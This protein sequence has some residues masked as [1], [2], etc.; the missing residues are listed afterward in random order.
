MAYDTT[1]DEVNNPNTNFVQP[2]ATTSPIA[3]DQRQAVTSELPR[4]AL[5]SADGAGT[6][7]PEQIA[8]IKQGDFAHPAGASGQPQQAL[9]TAQ[10]EP[11]P[12]IQKPPIDP[13]PYA[14]ASQKSPQVQEWIDRAAQA[15]GVSPDR[16]AAHMWAE[17]RMNPNAP[18]GADGEIGPMQMLPS[19][20]ANYTAHG[21][22][23]PFNPED[24]VLM[25]ALYMRDLDNKYGKDSFASVAH[26]NG[27][28]PA[29]AT[30]ARGIMP[31]APQS[32]E[33][34]LHAKPGSMTPQGLVQAGSQ[35]GPDAFFRYAVQTAPAGMP[36]SDVWRQA[37]ATLV[38]AMIER[39]DIAGAQHARDFVLQMSHAGA[40]QNLMGAQQ[41]LA[42]GNGTAAAQLLAKAHTFFPDGT[43]GRF[44]TDGKNV[45]AETVDENNPS[46]KL[47]PS[48][49]VTPDAIAGMLNQTTDPQKYL[50][51]LTAQ[52]KAAAEARL[53]LLHGD[54]YATG[55]QRAAMREEGQ[56]GAAAIRGQSLENAATIRANAAAGKPN[57]ALNNAAT[58]YA[59]TAL[60]DIT[61]PANEGLELGEKAKIAGVI[62]EMMKNGAT[63]LEAEHVG[64][65]L[66][67]KTLALLR[68]ADGNYGV[69]SKDS[70]NKPLYILPKE[71]GDKL[72]GQQTPQG[73]PIGAGAG[74]PA[75]MMMGGSNLAG[76]GG[77][78]QAALPVQQS[79]AVPSRI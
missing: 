68:G 45:W 37:E 34:D 5:P 64:R 30:Y 55:N 53:A 71:V 57:N 21:R 52:Q 12:Q 35:G 11:T 24:N 36:T 48:F 75:A 2:Q 47:G 4:P 76:A 59:D 49:Q 79:S 42:A 43:I 56:L 1:Q 51:T 73:S 67:D 19:T 15:T 62:Q 3:P 33:L 13:R 22:L 46:M 63:G 32:A 74:S 6:Y 61:N 7:S 18:R 9:A 26:Y 77:T 72:T 41:M 8:Q 39:G 25:S 65:G 20:A 28:G 58:K 60:S 16:I 50:Q 23:D 27:S 44:R 17:S 69:V 10:S 70:P 31:T 14:L 78:P 40:N 54:Y 29:A 38:G 66:H